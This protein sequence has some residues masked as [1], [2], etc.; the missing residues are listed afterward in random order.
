LRRRDF[1][2]LSGIGIGASMMQGI[3]VFGKGISMEEALIPVDTAL[4]NG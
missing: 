4:K 1:I 2:Y 3:P